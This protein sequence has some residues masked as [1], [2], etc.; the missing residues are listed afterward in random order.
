MLGAISCLSKCIMKCIYRTWCNRLKTHRQVDFGKGYFHDD[1]I[2]W[3]HFPRNWP[4]VWGIQRSPVNSSHKSQ[5]HEDLM[6]SLICVWINGWVNNR[7]AGDLRRYST[8]YDVTVMYIL[9]KWIENVQILDV[10]QVKNFRHIKPWYNYQ[11]SMAHCKTAETPLLMHWSYCSIVLSSRCYVTAY[12][13]VKFEKLDTWYVQNM[14]Y[15]PM[16]HLKSIPPLYR[17]L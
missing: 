6:F 5:W 15:N 2:N 8:H 3:K 7:E 17:G 14:D 10:R 11:M 12:N 9:Y 16:F 1:V 4:F 13:T